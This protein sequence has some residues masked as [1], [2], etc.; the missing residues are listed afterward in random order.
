MPSIQAAYHI[1]ADD[2]T[3]QVVTDYQQ[4]CK[5]ESSTGEWWCAV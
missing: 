1:H 2:P 4:H 3:V 5:S